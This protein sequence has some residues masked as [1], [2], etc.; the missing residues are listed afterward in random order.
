[1]K[2]DKKITFGIQPI[3]ARDLRMSNLCLIFV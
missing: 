2:I 3:V 1:M